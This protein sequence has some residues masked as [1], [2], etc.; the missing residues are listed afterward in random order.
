MIAE[1]GHL[2]IAIALAFSVLLAVYPLWGAAKGNGGMMALARPFAYGQFFFTAVAFALLVWGFVSN[3]FSIAYVAANSNSQ[4]PVV[5]R[6]TA[7]W[8]S[9]EGS[10]LLWML[11]QA[12][13]IAAV[14]IF[15][16]SMPLP[17][18]ARV[19]AILGLISIGFYLFMLTVSNPFDPSLPLIPVDG[20]DLNPLLQDPGMIIHPPL[21]Y[22]GYVGFSVA[23]AFAIAAL[24]SGK[25]DAAWARWS[26]PWTLAAWIF[27]TLGIAIG[28]WWAYYELGWGGWW[29]WD[30]VENASFMP[31]LVGTA[32]L[33]SLAVTEKRGSFKSWTVLLAISAFSLS[34]LG[35]F[36]VRS[37]VLVSVHAF[38]SDPTRGLFILILL[39][40]VVGG[41]LILYGL[42]AGKMQSYSRYE[43]VSREVMLLGNN[44]LL[45][46][47]MV[48]VFLGTMLPLV[49]KEI[50]LG[51]ISIGE[52]FFNGI[53]SW[54]VIPFALMVGLGPLMRW[55]RQAMKPLLKPLALALSLALILA[56]SLP[57]IWAD[58]LPVMVVI[59]LFLAFWVALATLTEVRQTVQQRQQG[60]SGITKISGSHWGMVLGHL[61]FAVTLIGITLVSHYEQERDI[62]LAPGQS[63]E[64]MEFNVVFERLQHR[65]GPNYDAD[66]GLF[67]VYKDGQE[68]T[69]LTSEKRFYRVQRT[70][71][72]EV[73]LDASLLR[74]VYIAMGEPLDD[75]T[76]AIRFYIKPFVRWI[77]LGAIIMV[78][79]GVM[80]LTDKRYR[81]RGKKEAAND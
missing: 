70:S 16:R 7:V 61:G 71:M 80:A 58:E 29:F 32:L 50:G 33:H 41:S 22:M 39:G 79:G 4:L 51:T 19:L 28:S 31:W 6:V 9:H 17:M 13:W 1:A 81:K 35:T 37:G 42:R 15:S 40:L 74:D 77:W 47:A 46:A 68:V 55:R 69:Q 10:F 43:L 3:D 12:G 18:I 64:V 67:T 72:T 63:V 26:R 30:P 25:L 44:V 48:V 23:F 20:R 2:A 38:A 65:E 52:P 66:E 56:Y 62:A 11:M 45:M 5:Y 54:L 36:L 76:W 34:L 24:L 75:E 60:W 59:G 14:A 57:K 8:G 21:L 27:L 73:G 49:H 78:I 53:Y